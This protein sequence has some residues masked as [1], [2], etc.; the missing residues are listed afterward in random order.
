[1]IKLRGYSAVES[2]VIALLASVM[3]LIY[4]LGNEAPP[5]EPEGQYDI[6][7]LSFPY[8]ELRVPYYL[9]KKGRNRRLEKEGFYKPREYEIVVKIICATGV[10]SVW[11]TLRA[12]EKAHYPHKNIR[13]E[14]WMSQEL[15]NEEDATFAALTTYEVSFGRV[16]FHFD[17]RD[18]AGLGILENCWDPDPNQYAIFINEGVIPSPYYYEYAMRYVDKIRNTHLPIEIDLLLLR[19]T[20]ETFHIRK[21]VSAIASDDP[22]LSRGFDLSFTV[23]SGRFWQRFIAWKKEK[24]REEGLTVLPELPRIGGNIDFS[25][26]GDR[27]PQWLGVFGHEYAKALSWTLRP[28]P[29]CSLYGTE[30]DNTVQS[31]L[32]YIYMREKTLDG[33]D[34][35]MGGMEALDVYGNRIGLDERSLRK[36]FIGSCALIPTRYTVRITCLGDV[37]PGVSIAKWGDVA[38][39]SYACGFPIELGNT[40]PNDVRDMVN[41]RCEGMKSCAMRLDNFLFG[42][43]AVKR[44]KA[45]YID[46]KDHLCTEITFECYIGKPSQY[47][48]PC[49]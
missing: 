24:T 21:E 39:S 22:Y 25:N 18:I 10:Y 12:I 6:L 17:E 47:A 40:R 44:P 3:I 7:D 30:V 33:I 5:V 15:Y 16:S 46:F 1:M 29:Q 34:D 19:E 38:M 2:V 31:E 45:L 23:V 4:I 37:L 27:T 28:I 14:I 36:S 41:K 48:F 26:P 43:P 11:N 42:D 49:G 13:L 20:T 9:D 35:I 32:Q 8:K